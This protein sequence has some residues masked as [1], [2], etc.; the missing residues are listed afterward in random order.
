MN[1]DVRPE[2]AA[3]GFAPATPLSLDPTE[4][5]AL[6]RGARIGISAAHESAHLHVAGA[7]PYVD[8]IAEAAGTLHAAL[9]LS[10]VAAGRLRSVDRAALLAMPGVVA[11]LTASDIPGANDCGPVIYDDPILAD[12]AL[13]YCGQPV[14]L[15]VATDRDSARRAA[16][17]SAACLDIEP[18]TPVLSARDAH[19]RGDALVPP[20]SLIRES[21]PGALAAALAAA[22][23]R[24]AGRFSLGGKSN[25]ISKARSPMPCRPKTRGCA[26]SAPPSTPAKCSI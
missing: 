5:A 13:R 20:A 11:V 19:A 25:S 15:I 8:D 9:A 7:A 2:T 24:L 4:A 3:P 18:A 16:A 26:C 22:P 17:H 21:A 23:H 12:S 6:R 14:A 10:P 1:Q